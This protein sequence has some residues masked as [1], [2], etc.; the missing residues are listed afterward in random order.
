M[1]RQVLVLVEIFGGKFE[2]NPLMLI[3]LHI[4]G[5]GSTLYLSLSVSVSFCKSL[6]SPDDKLSDNV[7]AIQT[8]SQ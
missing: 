6:S 7:W 1:S 4:L 5:P 2:M 3:F 8:V